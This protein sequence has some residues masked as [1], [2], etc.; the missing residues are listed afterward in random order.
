MKKYFVSIY[1]LLFCLVLSSCSAG[2]VFGPTLTLTSTNTP[3]F[4]PT[5]TFT[6]TPTSSP[7]PTITETLTPTHTLTPVKA[8]GIDDIFHCGDIFDI[9]VVGQP[10][11]SHYSSVT[12]TT[13]VVMAARLEIT[14]KG[15]TTISSLVASSYSV[16]GIVNGQTMNF[17]LSNNASYDFSYTYALQNPTTDQI[18]PNIPFNTYAVFGINPEGS[19]W[20]FNFQPQEFLTSTPMCTVSIPLS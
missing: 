14:Y 12:N 4:T 13:G 1:P 3:T 18:V 7:T 19:N 15:K 8:S 17:A 20:I 9:E 6:N 2:Q 10:I 5:A 16:S 11:I